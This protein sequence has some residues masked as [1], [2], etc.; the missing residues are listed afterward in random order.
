MKKILSYFGPYKGLPRSI[1]V[2]FFASIV[3][4]MG[5]FVN[6]LL[7]MLL[8][9]KVGIDVGIVGL[10]AATTAGL[11]MIGAMI[12]GRLIDVMGRKKILVIFRTLAGIGYGICAFTKDPIIITTILMVSGLFF[13]FTQ[14]VY[15]TI[16]T[17][18]TE[19]EQ[20]KASFS[21]N[22]MAL[23]IGYA[24]GPL[25]AGFLY[26]NYMVWLFLGD[27]ITTF[28]SVLLVVIFVPETMPDKNE[29]SRVQDKSF[30]KGEEGSLLSAMI[31]RPTLLMFSFIIVIYFIVFSQFNFGLSL[32]VKDIFKDNGGTY[33][34]LLMTI[35]AI[36]CSIFTVFITSFTKSIKPSLSIS[37]GGVL[38]VLGFG[39]IYFINSFTMFIISTVIWTTG[40]ILVATNTSVYIADH[41]PITHR[42]R[43]NSVFPIIR[44][45]GFMI[46]PL[47]AGVYVKYIDLKSLWLL[48]GLL[49]LI[50]ALM[51]YR[52]YIEDVR[53]NKEN[54]VEV[55]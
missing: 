55:V 18:L 12:G 26:E 45:I 54:Q 39:M 52:L 27:A 9:Y 43:F 36:M 30:E 14:P 3:N 48:I 20:R 21:L 25:L 6:P 8:T 13:G 17:D 1:Y 37:I 16:I 22:Y 31:K 5:N 42:G 23:N 41:T 35:N 44:R 34:G 49:S 38:Y 33:Y 29:I 4:N 40:E 24:V 46:G 32:Q 11:G 19:G 51:M 53:K 2:I 47:I 15:N 28:I 50:G 10:I 7:A